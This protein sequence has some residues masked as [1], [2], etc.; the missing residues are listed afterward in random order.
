[1]SEF[2]FIKKTLYYTHE[3]AAPPTRQYEPANFA[4]SNR[5]ARAGYSIKYCKKLLGAVNFNTVKIVC[6]TD[7]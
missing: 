7:E 2:K 3:L 1:M 6:K 4:Y 5:Y